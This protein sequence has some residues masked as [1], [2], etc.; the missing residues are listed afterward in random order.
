M[1]PLIK[2]EVRKGSFFFQSFT[3]FTRPDMANVILYFPQ[4]LD[5][6]MDARFDTDPDPWNMG[7]L[8]A[9]TATPSRNPVISL[10]H[11]FAGSSK[12]SRL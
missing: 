10:F 5:M 1:P 3:V 9:V 8:L 11:V 2:L 7:E 4:E 6:N 12:Y